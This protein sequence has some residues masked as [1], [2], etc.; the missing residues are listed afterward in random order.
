MAKTDAVTPQTLANVA[1]QFL[2]CPLTDEHAT[3]AAGVLNA[4]AADMQGFRKLALGDEEP[5]PTYAA[6]EGQP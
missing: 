5:A 2:D 1:Q 6:A 3:A 4:L